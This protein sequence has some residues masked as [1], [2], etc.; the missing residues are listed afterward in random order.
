[1]IAWL[2]PA[3]FTVHSTSPVAVVLIVRKNHYA[4]S[5]AHCGEQDERMS[6]AL[7]ETMSQ[8][9]QLDRMPWFIVT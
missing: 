3:V 6:Q 9:L 2:L 4:I 1:M 8:P 7:C 5:C